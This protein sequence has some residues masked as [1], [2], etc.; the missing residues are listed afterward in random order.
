M[1]RQRE[2]VGSRQVLSA[3][4]QTACQLFGQYRSAQL[5]KGHK[6][7]A[8]SLQAGGIGQKQLTNILIHYAIIICDFC[9]QLR[10]LFQ[11]LNLKKI[12]LLLVRSY[13]ICTFIMVE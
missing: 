6:P 2:A 10:T 9:N 7:Q 12:V 13:T 5:H 4:G 11:V 3:S 8:N 1:R